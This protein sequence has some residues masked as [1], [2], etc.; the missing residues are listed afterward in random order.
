MQHD[1]HPDFDGS[2][3][4]L[5][6][7]SIAR[8]EDCFTDEYRNCIAAMKLPPYPNRKRWEYWRI[9]QTLVDYF[10][11]FVRRKLKGVGFGLGK[12]HLPEFF[13][14]LGHELLCTD[15][16]LTEQGQREWRETAQHSA[17]LT[18]LFH[19][20]SVDAETFFKAASFREVD[21]N[22]I[23]DD[24]RGFDFC[25]S[26]GSLEHL[27]SLEKGLRF[28]E[29]TLGCLRPGGWSVHATEFNLASIDDPYCPTVESGS[30]CFYRTGDLTAFADRMSSKGHVVLPFEFKRG[31]HAENFLPDEHPYPRTDTHL[32]L[33]SAGCHVT[34]VLIAVCKDAGTPQPTTQPTPQPATRKL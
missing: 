28:I 15:G 2:Y 17:Q 25:W 26:T 32:S 24:I 29:N 30:F 34:S 23:P 4:S 3:V 7:S 33:I 27:G 11:D 31:A 5:G 20:L 8:Y 14:K 16:P 19:G 21:M 12:E 1:S 6:R 9:Y 10:P 13:V 18:D 22:A